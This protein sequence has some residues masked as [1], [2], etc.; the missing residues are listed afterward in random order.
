MT[1]ILGTHQFLNLFFIAS[2][3]I[4]DIGQERPAR[5][6]F[7]LLCFIDNLLQAADAQTQ[8]LS[9]LQPKCYS[10]E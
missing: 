7:N 6:C 8:A 9:V 10:I 2:L 3:Y 5:L 1:T 4:E